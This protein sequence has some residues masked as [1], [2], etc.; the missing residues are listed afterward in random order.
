MATP[1]FRAK[2]IG[3]K[4]SDGTWLFRNID[5]DFSHGVMTIT[6]PSGVGKSTLLKCINQTNVMDEGQVW[7]DDKTPDQ[8]GVPTWR[9]KIMYIPQRTTIMEGTPLDF[10]EEVRAFSA[11]K[12]NKDSY[13]DPVQIAL[14]WGIRPHLWHKKWN[15][16][17]GGEM[18]RISLAIGCSFRPEI[19][20]LDEPTSAL[21]EDSCDK[22]EKTLGQLNCLWV[23]HNPQQAHRISTAGELVMRGGDNREPPLEVSVDDENN[24]N[25][26]KK[27]DNGRQHDDEE[28]TE[29]GT[30]TT[31]GE[32]ARQN[33]KS[34]S[35]S[36]AKTV[37]AGRH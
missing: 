18:Q 13:D 21:D 28:G 7:L 27:K 3:K 24:N 4:N 36:S 15:T 37:Q 33:S 6:G 31:G 2:D 26:S 10:L 12:R 14:D 23:T 17:S 20:L 8:W 22:V 5:I 29:E 35:S 30:A 32:R 16:L 34:S 19:L 11:H 25:N 1:L 9:S